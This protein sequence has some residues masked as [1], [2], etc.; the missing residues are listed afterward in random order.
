MSTVRKG[1]IRLSTGSFAPPQKTGVAARNKG[2]RA[3]NEAVE[4]FS[5]MGLDCQKVIAS[6]AQKGA[7]GDIKIGVKRNRDGSIDDRDET[8]AFLRGEIKNRKTNSDYPFEVMEAAV[9]APDLPF[10]DLA[11][12]AK[13]K[14]L[15]WKRKKTPKGALQGDYNKA[16]LAI[17]GIADFAD[18]VKYAMLQQKLASNRKKKIKE[19][20]LQIAAL[21]R[22]IKGGRRA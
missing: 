8:K 9:G 13:T 2:N 21:E 22:A 15:L 4:I 5:A 12:S 16:Y 18:L 19:L 11:Q 20:E 6:G 3:E 14:V 17:M 10:S 7:E 1:V